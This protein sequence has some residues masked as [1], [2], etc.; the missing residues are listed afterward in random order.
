EAITVRSQSWVQVGRVLC[1][2]SLLPDKQEQPHSCCS[3]RSNQ[4]ELLSC[5]KPGGGIRLFAHLV[6]TAFGEPGLVCPSSNRPLSDG[7]IFKCIYHC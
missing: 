5:W 7:G 6:F 2:V 3:S 1:G 4:G